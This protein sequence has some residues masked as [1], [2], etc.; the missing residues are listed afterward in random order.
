MPA[1]VTFEWI[2]DPKVYANKFMTVADALDNTRAV[3]L[4]AA[5]EQMQAAIRDRFD[6][7]TDPEGVPWQEWS[8]RY[9]PIAEAYSEI[10][11]ILQWTGELADAASSTEAMVV[12][13]DTLFYQTPMLPSYGLAHDQG[14]SDR[15]TKGGGLPRR[16]FLGMD[17]N[18]ALRIMGFFSE[19]FDR[20]IDLFI[21]STGKVAPRHRIRG[22]GS[23]F[24]PRSAV[25]RGP[26]P[27]F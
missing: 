1:T 14:I 24:I 20:S 9:A 4:A 12:T 10:G 16:S 7:E 19:W 11:K 2:P 6:T 18:S 13:N 21:T 27:R 3:P 8:E 17:D 22:E 26:L 15:G 25:G 5:S 23:R